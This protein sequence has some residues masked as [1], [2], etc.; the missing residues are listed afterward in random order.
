MML[1]RDEIADPN[2]CLNKAKDD[3]QLFVLL[4]R[5]QAATVAVR[6]WVNER[7]RIGK[8][9]KT[10]PQILEAL[11]WI[12][13]VTWEQSQNQG[14]KLGPRQLRQ[15]ADMLRTYA[16]DCFPSD[17]HG[18]VHF[19]RAMVETAADIIDQHIDLFTGMA[20]TVEL[21]GGS[22]I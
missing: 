5:D 11:E 3:E 22:E 1:K 6:A 10:D 21:G 18:T 2:S 15:T 16:V 13:L 9:K 7:I 8:N 14:V 20:A 17:E 12:A 4:G 19:A